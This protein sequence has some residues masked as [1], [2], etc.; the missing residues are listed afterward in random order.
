MLETEV[1]VRSCLLHNPRALQKNLS[2]LVA[3]PLGSA[4]EKAQHCPIRM[5]T[6]MVTG[7]TASSFHSSS[8]Y[9]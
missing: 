7:T 6:I 5:E 4:S 9:L 3:F 2:F 1:Y 8:N